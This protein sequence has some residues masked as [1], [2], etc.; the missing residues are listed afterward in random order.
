MDTFTLILRHSSINK[1]VV[2]LNCK[3]GK[4][5]INCFILNI[6]DNNIKHGVSTDG[7]NHGNIYKGSFDGNKVAIK[8]IPILNM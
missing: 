6:E 5:S 7:G 8:C 1:E 3:W 2:V 4:F